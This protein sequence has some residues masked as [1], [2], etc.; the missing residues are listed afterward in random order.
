MSNIPGVS[1]TPHV[2]Q[3]DAKHRRRGTWDSGLSVQ[4]RQQ[5]LEYAGDGSLHRLNTS[6][7][8]SL[9]FARANCPGGQ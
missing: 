8:W 5:S 1:P 4:T 2:G 6:H 9:L 7:L 3:Q